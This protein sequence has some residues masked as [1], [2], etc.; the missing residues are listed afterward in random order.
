MRI[1]VFSHELYSYIRENCRE[2]IL[3]GNLILERIVKEDFESSRIDGFE[4]IVTSRLSNEQIDSMT[5]L[6]Y[7]FVPLTGL[8]G[9]DLDYVAN[10]NITILNTHSTAKYIAERGFSILLALL[11]RIPEQHGALVLHKWMRSGE[12]G[13]WTTLYNKAIGIYGYGYIGN[14]FHQLIKPFGCKVYTIDRDKDYEDVIVV[15]DLYELAR[16]C[17]I[18]FISVPAN[19]KTIETVDKTIFKE[20]KDGYVINIARGKIVNQ[21]DLAE[22]LINNQINGYG[23]DVWYNYPESNEELCNP[24][25]HELLDCDKLVMTPHNAWNTDEKKEIV[26]EEIVFNIKRCLQNS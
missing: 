16:S 25:D 17:D 24:M 8:E 3:S 26:Q 2:D 11:G 20:M 9:F 6:K 10:K 15:K 22:A 5:N 21:T 1:G 12:E 14:A 13:Q 18:L 4:G 23:S 19:Q 7:I